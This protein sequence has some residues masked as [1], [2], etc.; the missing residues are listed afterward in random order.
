MM[1]LGNDDMENWLW[2]KADLR[3]LRQD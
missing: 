2:Q 1:N 3:M